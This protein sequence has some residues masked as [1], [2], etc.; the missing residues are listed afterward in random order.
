MLRKLSLKQ[1]LLVGLV[2]IFIISGFLLSIS[3][4]GLYNIH[5]RYQ[6]LVYLK[7]LQINFEEAFIGHL[8]FRN[9]IGK[10]QRDITMKKFNVEKDYKKC[11]LGKFYYSEK[12]QELEEKIPD[13]K[14]YFISL[15][16]P[17]IELHNS[18]EY[19]EN[20]LSMGKREEAIQFYGNEFQSILENILKNLEKINNILHKKLIMFRKKS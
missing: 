7:E 17:H 13:L 10:F 14:E 20:L 3:I 6:N 15:E 1:K 9:E 19:L 2:G 18:V 4:F 11:L 8:R 16:K 5:N 12:R